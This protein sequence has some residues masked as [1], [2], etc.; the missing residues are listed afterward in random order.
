MEVLEIATQTGSA[1][2]AAHDAGIVH[3]DLKPENVMLRPD[4][5]VKVLDF[6]L[7]KL[8][9]S[10]FAN[11]AVDGL[12]RSI[13][14]TNPG[15]AFEELKK[16]GSQPFALMLTSIGQGLGR[17]DAECRPVLERAGLLSV[18]NS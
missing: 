3:R 12:T 17:T 5:Y 1:L 2:A 6:G 18:K 11:D 14:D 9:V 13:M 15:V 7:A 16:A 8:M 4:G 10:E